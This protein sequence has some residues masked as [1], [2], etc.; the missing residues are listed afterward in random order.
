MVSL[1]SCKS[2][3]VLAE[4]GAAGA[5]SSDKIISGHYATPN[6]FSTIYIKSTAR[7]K[8]EDQTQ[9]VTAEI[10]IKKNEK[11]LVS[12]R[13]LGITM[14]K[15]LITPSEV[16]YYEKIN[17]KYFEGDYSTLSQWLGADLDFV[18]VQNLLIGQAMDDLSKGNYKSSV[19]DQL[20]KLESSEAS[21]VTKT[22]YFESAK[23]LLKRQ[24]LIQSAR[25]RQL[26]VEYPDYKDY[27]KAVMPTA[28]VVEALQ[29]KGKAN[30]SI[31][32]NSI[33]FNE[34]LSFP[35]SVPEGYERVFID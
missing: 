22:F 18:K 8:D 33:T 31:Q 24:E 10:K 19:E 15:A 3:A 30:I 12:I 25:G 28:V 1:S 13:F 6:D 7:Y 23:F 4:K 2:K 35:Y 9:N 27:G 20:Y 11:I 29:K 26:E 17:G 5:L 34:E 14:A 21:Q 32:Y 16:K